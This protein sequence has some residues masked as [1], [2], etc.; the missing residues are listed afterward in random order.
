MAIIHH[1]LY[2]YE[3][4]LRG[5]IPSTLSKTNKKKYLYIYVVDFTLE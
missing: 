1:F 4:H 5:K 3:T 2:M